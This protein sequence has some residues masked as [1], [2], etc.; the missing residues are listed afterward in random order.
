MN[1]FSTVKR[2]YADNWKVENTRKL[3]ADEVSAV[4]RAEVTTSKFGNSVCFYMKAGGRAYFPCAQDS[5]LSVGQPV[6]VS[7]LEVITL[8]KSGEENITRVK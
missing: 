6:D 5:Q 8:S 1:I 2:L 3:S 4:E 7:A